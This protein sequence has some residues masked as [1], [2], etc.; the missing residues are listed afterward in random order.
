MVRTVSEGDLIGDIIDGKA[1]V[2]LYS[3]GINNAH[4]RLGMFWG[5]TPLL[6]KM[7]YNTDALLRSSRQR[8]L[9]AGL[10]KEGDVVIQT[11]GIMTGVSGSNML[12]VSEIEK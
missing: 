4:N 7:H 6:D 3:L 10:V 11:A 2:V 1:D 9:R 12:V 8:A 5:A